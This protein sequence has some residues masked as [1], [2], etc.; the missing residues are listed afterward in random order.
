MP[1]SARNLIILHADE[2]RGDCV[3]FA[4]N[5][6]VRTPHLDAFAGQGEVLERHFTVHPK[7]VPSRVAMMTGRFAH[8]DGIR[9]VMEE[10]LLPADQP[11]LMKTLK[12]AGFETAV[13]GLNHCWADFWNGNRPHGTVDWHSY[14]PP[15]D[16][17]S[18]RRIPL[19]PAGRRP[20]AP[21]LADG[22]DLHGRLAGEL[23]PFSDDVR[24]ESAI[25]YLTQARDR[26]KPFFM[27]LNLSQPHPPYQV[28]EPWYS[29][30]D[31]AAI[32]PFP[33][34]LPRNPSL[35]FRAMRR[36]RTHEGPIEPAAVREV[37]A[38][39]YGMIAK[40]DHLMG[41][42]LEA[43]AGEGL[44]EDTIVVFTSDHGDFAGQ[45]GLGEK[46]DTVM[47]DCLLRVPCAIRIPGRAGGRRC[48]ALTQHIDLPAT[49]LELL[50]VAPAAGWI[51]HGSSLLPVLDGRVRPAAVFADGG[52]EASMRARFNA[53][54]WHKG[55]K[56]TAGKQHTYHHEPDSM[57]RTSMVRSETHK[58][59]MR[60]TGGHELYDLAADPW[61]LDNRY[62]D[63]AMSGVQAAL[64]ERLVGWHLR[65]VSDRPFQPQVG[66]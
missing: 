13:F 41:R 64:M 49:M 40:I 63:P 34:A 7:C 2:L 45:Y 32:T 11:D 3:G 10:N 60:E 55:R 4:G 6:E 14:V 39:Y 54:L 58:L 43:I 30:V 1:A 25:H 19:P 8:S 26:S 56:A 44:F 31:P 5:R 29:S 23:G 22:F 9:T 28:E 27:Q 46:F 52:H 35:P 16:A 66:A 37:L 15:F 38:T 36:H 50:G 59:V 21:Q 18:N 42:V 33:S 20:D 24:A 47:A 48:D 62:G 12:A 57:A 17:I 61:E 51:M 53:G 65:T